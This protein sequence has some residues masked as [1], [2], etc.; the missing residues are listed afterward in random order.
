[1]DITKQN[2]IP[3]NSI[4]TTKVSQL[5]ILQI[6]L[7]VVALLVGVLVYLLDRQPEHVY[8]VPQWLAKAI[9]GDT[10]LGELSNYVPTFVHVFAFI[11]LTMAIVIPLPLYRRYLIGV[12]VFWY[13]LDSLFEI[14]QTDAIGSAIATHV[15]KGF[16]GIPFLENTATYF[17]TSTFDG[18]DLV[19]IGLGAMAAYYTVG[20]LYARL[21]DDGTGKDNQ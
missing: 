12:C 3:T 13:A 6:V 8:F 19:S 11:L 15:P 14:A 5:V 2:N 21:S 10:F 16:A 7:A 18:L 4:G 1:M 20:T 9:N 17:L